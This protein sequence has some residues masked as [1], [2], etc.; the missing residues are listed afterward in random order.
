M[1]KQ[2]SLQSYNRY[3]LLLNLNKGTSYGEKKIDNN[4]KG[5]ILNHLQEDVTGLKS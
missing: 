1:S 2:N 4:G 3:L 5:E